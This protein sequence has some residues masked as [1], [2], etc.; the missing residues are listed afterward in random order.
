GKIDRAALP[1]PED[2]GDSDCFV[3]PAG[4]L[5]SML[6]GIWADVLGI[7]RIGRHDN[8]FE[9]GG[10][11]IRC[12]K[13]V[14]AIQRAGIDITPR[15]MFEHQDV[16]A[17]AQALGEHGT[18]AAPTFVALA[19][20]ARNALPL[21]FAQQRLWFLWNLQPESS[22]YHVTGAMRLKGTLDASALR[23]SFDAL[24]QRHESLRTTFA[25]G[26]DGHATQNIHANAHYD[27][28]T[29][30]AARSGDGAQV[31]EATEAW[32]AA[33]AA[34]P[35]DLTTGPLLRVG[36]ARVAADEHVL[37]V[38]MHHIV[39]DGWSMGVLLREFVEGYRARVSGESVAQSDLPIQYA[40][41]AVWQRRWLAD[42]EQERQLAYW[43]ATL[44]GEQPVLALPA[45]RPRQ[46]LGAWRAASETVPLPQALAEALQRVARERN[47]TLF[48]VLL[49]AFD[50]LLHRYTGETDIRIGV[51]VANRNRVET[52]GLIGFFVNTQVLKAELEGRTTLAA[53]L[54]Q[55]KTRAFEAQAH[56][57][58]PF[59][60]L[61]DALQPER[62]LSHT[63]LF[64]VAFNHQRNDYQAADTLE[65]LTVE[66][67]RVGDGAAQ[68]ELT[69]N[70]QELPDGTLNV[71]L[72]Y[73]RELFDAETMARF[74]RHYVRMLEALTGDLERSID[75]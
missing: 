22:A 55:V 66:R 58:L 3:A 47:A 6:A 73:A 19:A 37:V 72:R 56:Q 65:G 10:D 11:S 63:P 38:V 46:A 29:F 2:I 54:D 64:Q 31:T 35:F 12:L 24:V 67:Y 41:Y 44:G 18:T 30:D 51:P 14:A 74:G 40:D 8:F 20:E 33:L 34:Q 71:S 50:A 69:V 70:T 42:G 26:A 5:E 32:A 61:V 75:A 57:D 48:T 62:S 39:S 45:D 23:A 4:E 52:E 25:A 21:S 9:R 1:E 17:L 60:V 36:V 28:R 16:A 27:Y 49:A 43:R 7:E 53:L 68:F 15:L 13:A 59:D